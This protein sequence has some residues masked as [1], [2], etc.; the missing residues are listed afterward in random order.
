ME[1]SACDS[2]LHVIK[3]FVSKMRNSVY[4]MVS[5]TTGTAAE[6]TDVSQFDP[7]WQRNPRNA[8]RDILTI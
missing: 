1:V 2:I 3:S 4:T 6:T 5:V 8:A 7:R